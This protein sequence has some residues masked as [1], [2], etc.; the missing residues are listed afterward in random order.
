M[1]TSARNNLPEVRIVGIRFDDAQLWV[2]LSDEREIGL[3]YTK[4]TWLDWLASATPEQRL[5]WQIEPYGYAVW[6][7]ALDDGFELVH[8][9]SLQ[10]LPHR[11][12]QT[13]AEPFLATS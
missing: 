6:W 8:V 9:L 4:I 10:P 11:P 7:E 5:A 3:P 1:N 2:E 13:Q 12:P